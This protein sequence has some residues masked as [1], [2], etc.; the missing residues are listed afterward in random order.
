MFVNHR[1]TALLIGIALSFVESPSVPA[2]KLDPGD[3]FCAAINSPATGQEVVLRAGDYR[4]PCTI[5]KGGN[6]GAPLVIRAADPAQRPRI[7][8]GGSS[9]NVLDIKADYVTIRQLEFGPTLPDVDAIRI[10]SGNGIT[11]EDCLF[12]DLGGIAVAANHTSVHGLVVR[13]NVIRSSNTTAMYFGCHDGVSCTVSELLV[14]RNF[15]ERV[16]AP[17]P[18]IGYGVQI[19]LNSTG[20]IRDNVIVDTKGPPIMVYGARDLASVTLVERNLVAGSLTSA[21]LLIGGGPVVVRNNI[22]IGNAQAG[23]A[24][25]DYM[26]RHLL[27]GVIVSHN[28]MHGNGAGGITVPVGGLADVSIVN[29]AVHAR[30]GTPA[31]PARQPGLLLAG[32]VDCPGAPC[33]V[34]PDSWDLSPVPGSPLVARGVIRGTGG[35]LGTTSSD[36]G[37]RCRPRWAPLSDPWVRSRWG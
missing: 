21:G 34:N 30:T 9:A 4:G 3:D 7:V 36:A 24:L 8:Y 33:F 10:V 2:V 6:P 16:R 15:I 27:R 26:R 23:I 19:K 37:V 25:Q 11:V 20:L 12:W 32:N 17:G 22:A 1:R 28:T 5:K 18:E 14:E 29:N 35:F 31:L 13:R